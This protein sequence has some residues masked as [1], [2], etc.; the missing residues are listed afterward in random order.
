MNLIVF[1]ER[2]SILKNI[3][4]QFR[5]D[6]LT[7]IVGPSGSGKTSLL[8][9][10][11]GFRIQ[12]VNGLIEINGNDI[13][14]Y[15]NQIAYVMQESNMYGLLTVQESMD[16]AAKLKIGN[17]LNTLEV[18]IKISTILNLLTLSGHENTFVKHLSG[19]QRKR[20][21]IA[22]EIINDP[23]IIFLDECTTGLDSIS[24]HQCI[25]TL[26]KLVFKG[27]TVIC[28]I[29]QPSTLMLEFFDHIYALADGQCIYQG[30][31]Q[32][33]LTFLK[34]IN[35]ECPQTYNPIDYLMEIANNIYGERN[36]DLVRKTENGKNEDY[37]EI[38]KDEHDEK[39]E[40][41]LL[42]THPTF[43]HQ[44]YYLMQRNY[45][46]MSRD[47]TYTYFRLFAHLFLGILV[48]LMFG[49]IGNNA[50]AIVTDFKLLFAVELLL[51]FTSAY[52]QITYCK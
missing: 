28:T 50:S 40:E 13:E 8:N 25:E 44:L 52:S 48:G 49:P 46:I 47:V 6:K 10:L 26:K 36:R 5:C 41:C 35:L 2:K 14:S 15:R 9:A 7:G 23:K 22:I 21:S 1:T 16:F 43:G 27:H 37:C 31:L 12:G 29:H 20:L 33:L 42:H 32:N 24:S 11:A 39:S 3:S 19:G 51:L 45:L 34:D 17:I 30:G 18:G 4:G 38:S